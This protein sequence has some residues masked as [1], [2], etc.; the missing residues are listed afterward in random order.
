MKEQ[1]QSL[2]SLDFVSKEVEPP[3]FTKLE[4]MLME[5]SAAR[6]HRAQVA[7]DRAMRAEYE[8]DKL[9]TENEYLH[10]TLNGKKNP[11]DVQALKDRIKSLEWRLH[12]VGNTIKDALA[13]L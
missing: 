5:Q 6:L 1:T 3:G 4:L 2:G 12:I 13:H 9:R 11:D 8:N 7:E 10:G